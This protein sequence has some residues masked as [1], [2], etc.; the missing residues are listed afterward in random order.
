MQTENVH[1]LVVEDNLGYLGQTLEWLQDFGYQQ[2]ETATSATQAQEKLGEPFDVIIADM[3]MEQDDSGFAIVDEVKA[4]NLSAV[5][6][7]LTATIQLAI[8][9]LRL[10]WGHGTTFPKIC[11]EMFLMS[12]MLDSRCDRLFQRLGQCSERAMD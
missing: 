10:N 6:I 9:A 12:C 11:E 7:I 5:V 8:V 2:I 4:R 3:R 1:L